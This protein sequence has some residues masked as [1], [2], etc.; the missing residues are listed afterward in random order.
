MS[1]QR[2]Q[3]LSERNRGFTLLELLLVVLIVGMVYSMA[4]PYTKAIY[5]RFQEMRQL[6]E[7][8][9]FLL[10]V[11][12]R[13]FLYG[14]TLIVN[15]E[16][17]KLFAESGE[18]IL[19]GASFEME[20]PIYFFPLGTTSGGSIVI[21]FGERSYRVLVHRPGGEIKIELL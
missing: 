13:A 4:I 19:K 18:L 1:C 3:A 11:R 14:E 20:R 7:V 15:C 21:N 9:A 17:E 2:H 12:S 16:G 5:E 8:R 6:E 10:E